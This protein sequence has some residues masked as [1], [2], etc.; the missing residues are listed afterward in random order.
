MNTNTGGLVYCSKCGC[1]YAGD[2]R[3]TC[4]TNNGTFTYGSSLSMFPLDGE[5]KALLY[6][7]AVALEKIAE[8]NE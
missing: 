5:T 6:R 3:H 2:T 4:S 7:I 1:A 8:L